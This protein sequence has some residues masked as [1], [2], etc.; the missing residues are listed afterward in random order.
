MGKMKFKKVLVSYGYGAG[1]ST[2]Y[3][4]H[5]SF[6]CTDP[7][8][9]AMAERDASEEE[10]S[11]YLLETLGDDIY[12]GGWSDIEVIPVMEGSRIQINEYD[13]AE[14]I[15]FLDNAGFTV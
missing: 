6:L 5:A 7:T 13:G 12:M 11:E 2:W 1:W 8:L 3:R 9:V 15:E 14:S 10:V 4:K